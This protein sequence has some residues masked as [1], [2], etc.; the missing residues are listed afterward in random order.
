MKIP[1]MTAILLYTAFAIYTLPAFALD[2]SATPAMQACTNDADCTLADGVCG[3]ECG[4]VPLNNKFLSRFRSQKM[5]TCG[6]GSSSEP[7]CQTVPA[8]NPTCI[9]NRCTIGTAYQEHASAADYGPAGVKPSPM[10]LQEE[11]SE[12]PEAR[13]AA[14]IAPAAGGTDADADS[15][16][17]STEGAVDPANDR[18]NGFTAYDLPNHGASTTGTLG[19]ITSSP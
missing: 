19:T 15:A 4:L 12:T 5:A 10:Q 9:H 8:L 13:N 17:P 7:S 18:H 14:S 3:S 2:V 11:A 1:A 16:S 6:A